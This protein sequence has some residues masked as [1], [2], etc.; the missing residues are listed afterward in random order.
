MLQNLKD[1]Y[2]SWETLGAALDGLVGLDAAVSMLDQ[3]YGL[4]CGNVD[5]PGANYDLIEGR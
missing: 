2:Q 4:D 3:L 5:A 1:M